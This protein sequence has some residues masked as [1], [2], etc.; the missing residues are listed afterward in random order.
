[1][2]FDAEVHGILERLP[3]RF[4]NE[5]NL[6]ALLIRKLNP[7]AAWV[8]NSNSM[9]PMFWPPAT[10]KLARRIKP[11]LGK[12]RRSLFGNTY[13]TTGSW[14]K[15]SV[16][17]ATDPEWRRSFDEILSQADLFD[18]A[19]FDRDAIRKCWQE[20]LRGEGN[21]VGDVEKLVQIG[22]LSRMMSDAGSSS[23]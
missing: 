22:I 18:P 4:R 6:G 14:P 3:S 2:M 10:H 1:M 20:F 17:Y 23:S 16:L 9:L 12:L 11:V 8:M 7:K 21:R 5:K 19:L 13:R 15:H